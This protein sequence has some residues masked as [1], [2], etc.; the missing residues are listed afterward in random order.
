MGALWGLVIGPHG[1]LS[2]DSIESDVS[3]PWK[4]G[5]HADYAIWEFSSKQPRN[6]LGMISRTKMQK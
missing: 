6:F 1:G 2:Q 4:S 5:P 3:H